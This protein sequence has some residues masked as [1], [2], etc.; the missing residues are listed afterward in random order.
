MSRTRQILSGREAEVR[1]DYAAGM[2]C[3]SLAR[4]YGLP[5][6]TMLSWLHREGVEIRSQGKLSPEDMVEIRRL[7]TQGWTHQR[8]A[9]QFG[10]SRAAVSLRLSRVIDS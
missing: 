9:D 8:I 4:K 7:R 6:N 5:M 2:G 3:V 1:A 10:V